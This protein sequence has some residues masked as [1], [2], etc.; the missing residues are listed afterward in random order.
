[1]HSNSSPDR[2]HHFPT[3]GKFSKLNRVDLGDM[4]D[5]WIS[6]LPDG[7]EIVVADV[8]GKPSQLGVEKAVSIVQS[9]AYLEARAHQLIA[10]FRP[11]AGSWRLITIDFGVESA[12]QQ[13]E[14][15]MC[16]AFVSTVNTDPSFADPYVEIGFTIQRPIGP[17]PM[18]ELA[19]KSISG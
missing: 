4:S 5:E 10:S 18:F 6:I 8:R 1:M 13:S 11:S 3:L 12:R 19:V 16:F 9:R 2:T 7:T 14:F 15:L 17:D